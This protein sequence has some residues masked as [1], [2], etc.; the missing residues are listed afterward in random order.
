[1]QACFRTLE[2]VYSLR[3]DFDK[4]LK[5]FYDHIDDVELNKIVLIKSTFREMHCHNYFLDIDTKNIYLHKYSSSL[6]EQ[7]VHTWYDVPTINEVISNSYIV[8]DLLRRTVA[9]FFS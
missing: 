9:D 1:M 7:T 4:I 3:D 5:S 2:N 6:R 8:D